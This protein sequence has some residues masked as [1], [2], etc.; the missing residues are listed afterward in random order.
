MHCSGAGVRKCLN[1]QFNADVI[2]VATG[3]TDTGL[4]VK[5]IVPVLWIKITALKGNG[6]AGLPA[7]PF[8]CK[9]NGRS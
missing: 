3:D 6:S 1:A 8:S 2:K 4:F 9:K 5:L 7:P